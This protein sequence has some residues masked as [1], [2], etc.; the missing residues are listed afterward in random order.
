MAADLP[1]T[2]ASLLLRLQDRAGDAWAEFLTIYERAIV[3]FARR[4]GLQEADAR[5]VTQEVLAAVERK[6]EHWRHDASAGKFRGWLF[7]VARNLAVDR[8]VEEAQRRARDGEVAYAFADSS[9]STGL[10]HADEFGIDYRRQ[11][12]RWAADRIRPLVSEISWRAFCMTAIDGVG[13]DEVARQLGIS[14][15]AVYAAK[16]RVLARLR[17]EID[18]LK[19]REESE[20]VDPWRELEDPEGTR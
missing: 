2:R 9:R 14:R 20:S 8:V 4:R 18:R 3:D 17:A 19:S 7:R 13:G 12:V 5:D 11:L 10:S 6:V 16:F 15:G 1:K